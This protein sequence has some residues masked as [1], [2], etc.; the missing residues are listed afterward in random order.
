ML[1]GAEM[2]ILRRPRAAC[3]QLNQL[4]ALLD[5]TNKGQWEKNQKQPI[6]QSQMK[7][8]EKHCQGMRRCP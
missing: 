3:K 2:A 7:T 4:R 8:G 5:E 1:S 6:G